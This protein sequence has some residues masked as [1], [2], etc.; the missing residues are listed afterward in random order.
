[1]SDEEK[2]QPLIRVRMEND[3]TDYP[4]NDVSNAAFFFRERLTRAFEDKERADGIFLEMIGMMT[5][6]AFALEGYTNFVGGKL[7]ERCVARQDK[8]HSQ[9]DGY[10]DRLE[11]ASLPHRQRID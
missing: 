6:T 10:G 1:L 4:H 3:V 2:K 9:D 7:I 5:M 8:S 11:Q